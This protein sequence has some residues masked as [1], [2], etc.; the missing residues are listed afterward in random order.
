MTRNALIVGALSLVIAATPALA[1]D[2]PDFSGSWTLVVDPNAAPTG[3]RGGGRGGLGQGAML[4]MD[5]TTL[6]ITRTTQ[7]GEVKTVYKL[8]GSESKNTVAMGR[9]GNSVEQ[10]SK[11]VWD[12]NK[13]VVTTNY[14]MGDNAVVTTQTFSLDASGQ[15]VVT[16]EGPGRGG[17]RMNTTMTYKKG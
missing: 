5:A 3:G 16:F 8:D 13:L 10:V 7:G 6:T 2:K 11:A 12:G 14:M 1:Q 4:T 9:G 15:L 17:E